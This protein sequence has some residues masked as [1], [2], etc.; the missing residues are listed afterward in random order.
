MFTK[1]THHNN[2]LYRLAVWYITNRLPS[3]KECSVLFAPFEQKQH[4]FGTSR[5]TAYF[6]GWELTCLLSSI[7]Q[8]NETFER[9]RLESDCD[10]HKK[11]QNAILLIFFVKLITFPYTRSEWLEVFYKSHGFTKFE[12]QTPPTFPC[13]NRFKELGIVSLSI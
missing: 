5:Q 2:E 11:F 3:F 4:K 12:I 7:S 13:V 8:L 6:F 10:I 9:S 1:N